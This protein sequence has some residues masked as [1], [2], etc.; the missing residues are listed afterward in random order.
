MFK[1]ADLL[2]IFC[3]M[4][5]VAA[6]IAEYSSELYFGVFKASRLFLSTEGFVK[7]YP[8]RINHQLTLKQLNLS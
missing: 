6:R 3:S 7:V 8:F 5:D 4:A 2:Y 1:E